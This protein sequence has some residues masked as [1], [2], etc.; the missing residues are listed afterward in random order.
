M[1]A[2]LFYRALGADLRGRAEPEKQFDLLSEHIERLRT[3]HDLRYSEIVVMVERNLG[4]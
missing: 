1:R 3:F 2:R 4:L